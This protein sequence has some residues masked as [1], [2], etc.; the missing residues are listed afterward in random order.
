MADIQVKIGFVGKLQQQ[1]AAVAA[2]VKP[3]FVE[4]VRQLLQ[5]IFRRSQERVSGPVLKVRTGHLR[6]SAFLTVEATPTGAAGVVGYRAIYAKWQEQ[7]TRPY[8]IRARNRRALRFM[9]RD[10]E[11]VFAKSV[12]HPG[13]RPR[14]FLGPSVEDVRPQVRPYLTQLVLD[15]VNGAKR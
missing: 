15:V 7:G 6:R 13:L 2:R 3:A 5:D 14:P 4:G 12:R 1:V 9:G 11:P 8:T 10:G